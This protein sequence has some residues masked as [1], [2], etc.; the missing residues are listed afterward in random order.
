MSTN[1][2]PISYSELMNIV[3][4]NWKE[5][6]LRD[7]TSQMDMDSWPSWR[8]YTRREFEQNLTAHNFFCIDMVLDDSENTMWSSH[9][10]PHMDVIFGK[11]GLSMNL[12]RG[13]KIFDSFDTAPEF[14]K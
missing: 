13:Q 10:D 11:G 1:E 2:N 5:F 4:P 12:W 6:N 3:D 8:D 7:L 14:V 9:F